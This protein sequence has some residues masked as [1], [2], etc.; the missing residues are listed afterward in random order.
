LATFGKKVRMLKSMTGYGKANLE[1]PGKKITIEI[2]SLN[3]KTLDINMRLPALYRNRETEIRSLLS[4]RLERGKVDFNINL[5]ENVQQS[6]SINTSLAL[7]YFEELKNLAEATGQQNPDYL[8]LILRMPDVVKSDLQQ[9][10]E[11][12]W[13]QVIA[14]I[15][16]ACTDFD[17]FRLNEGGILGEDLQKRVANILTLLE[18]TEKY[19]G[20]R[21]ESQRQKLLKV[22]ADDRIKE[23]IDQNRFEQE[24]IYFMEKT[25]FTEEKIRLRKHC[26]Y[27]LQTIPDEQNNGRKLNFIGQ[28]MGREIN[29]LGAKANH[30]EIQRLVVEMK[31]ELEKIKEQV[32]N[33]L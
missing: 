16:D 26:D 3:S 28:E 14:A 8:S 12:E 7:R 9:A 23:K 29:T 24:M 30:A 25:D 11:D 27:F 17:T 18:N 5:E 20:Q 10:D 19:E 32:L 1:I 4:Q 15:Q 33:I 31:D 21:I 13:Q 6:S 2:K 22:L